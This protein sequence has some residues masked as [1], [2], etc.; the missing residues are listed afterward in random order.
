MFYTYSH[1][2]P[3]LYLQEETSQKFRNVFNGWNK[4]SSNRD[5]GWA[6]DENLIREQ[7]SSKS[8]Q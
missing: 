5:D 1:F 2:S 6:Q 4:G 7:T 3:T 8:K